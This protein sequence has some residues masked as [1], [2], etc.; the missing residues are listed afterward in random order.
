MTQSH[1]L[2]MSL[3]FKHK[4]DTTVKKL[5]CMHVINFEAI[6]SSWYLSDILRILPN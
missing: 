4:K 1:Q 2:S 6:E 5:V 3:V